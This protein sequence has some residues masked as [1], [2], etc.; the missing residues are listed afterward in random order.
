MPSPTLVPS[1]DVTV[2]LV[3]D[4]FGALGR[5]Y[6]ETDEEKADLESVID[7]MMAGLYKRPV[8]VIAFNT[9]ERWSRDVS[10]AIARE[11]LSRAMDQALR[12]PPATR[13]FVAF[14][15]GDTPALRSLQV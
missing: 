5:A 6:L 10:E 3:L 12:V 11:V 9:A 8:R 14:H 7:G 2:Y 13:D 1:F 15:V 4:D